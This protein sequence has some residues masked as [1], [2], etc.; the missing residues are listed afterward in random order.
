[1]LR[2]DLASRF[3]LRA[4]AREGPQ[5]DA[6]AGELLELYALFKQGTQGDISGARPGLLDI[7]GRAKFDAWEKKKGLSRE[8]AQA[9]YVQL[10]S[11]LEARYGGLIVAGRCRLVQE[12]RTPLRCADC[13]FDW[14]RRLSR[15]E[16]IAEPFPAEF[17]DLVLRHVPCAQ[18]LDDEELA[19]LEALVRIFNSEK[20]FQGAGGLVLTDEMRIVMP[21]ALAYS[22]CT[23]SSS[24]V[25]SIR[26]SRP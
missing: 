26:I 22:Y 11:E 23:A 25:R 3:R 5:V 10:V 8:A 1:M 9:A 17:H 15:A 13:M 19:K 4:D 21:R 16:V 2:D 7:K 20:T 6:E 14:W 12:G 18:L 24:I